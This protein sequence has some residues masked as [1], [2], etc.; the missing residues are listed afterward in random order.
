ME[1][2]AAG[3][4]SGRE[5]PKRQAARKN[6]T[7]LTASAA[8]SARGGLM[9]LAREAQRSPRAHAQRCA[10]GCGLLAGLESYL[11]ILTTSAPP[12]SGARSASSASAAARG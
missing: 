10:G 9:R 11:L 5:A 6:A 4:I 2:D 12:T 7:R 1:A 3:V 8:N